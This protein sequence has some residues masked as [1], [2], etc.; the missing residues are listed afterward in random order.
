[1]GYTWPKTM[2]DLYLE[3]KANGCN[4]PKMVSYLHLKDKTKGIQL[5]SYLHLEDKVTKPM[6]YNWP[7]KQNGEAFTPGG[8]SPWDTIDPK[9]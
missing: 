8:L 6:G 5:V 4:W 1:M 3:D 2:S 7:K 9:W